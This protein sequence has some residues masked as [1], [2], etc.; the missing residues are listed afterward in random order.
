[1]YGFT[2]AHSSLGRIHVVFSALPTQTSLHTQE[3]V[4]PALQASHSNSDFRYISLENVN[5]HR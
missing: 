5:A 3:Q 1:M 4:F 2:A